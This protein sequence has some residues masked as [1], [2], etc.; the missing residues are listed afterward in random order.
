MQGRATADSWDQRSRPV[1]CENVKEQGGKKMEGGGE[2]NVS[3]ET[4][5]DIASSVLFAIPEK[6]NEKAAFGRF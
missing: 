2:G 5:K 3:V 4:E 6:R 1:S